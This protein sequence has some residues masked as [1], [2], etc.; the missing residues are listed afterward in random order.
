MKK[1]HKQKESLILIGVLNETIT[2]EV[3]DTADTSICAPSNVPLQKTGIKSNKVFMVGTS[4]IAPKSQKAELLYDVRGEA[5]DEDIVPKIRGYILLSKGNFSKDRYESVCDKEE[6]NI[7]DAT[8]I[9]IN[10]N[11][12]TILTGKFSKTTGMWHIPLKDKV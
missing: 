8:T 11:G 9:D 4:N 2:P 5:K 12:K 10:N 1:Y 6:V 3:Y 7:Y